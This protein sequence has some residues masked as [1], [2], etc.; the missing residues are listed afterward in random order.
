MP[1]QRTTLAAG[2]RL[3]VEQVVSHSLPARWSIPYQ[4]AS[5][6]VLFPGTGAT[7]LRSA[8]GELLADPLTAFAL[9][10]DAPYQLRPWAGP[11]ASVVVSE[12]LREQTPLLPDAAAWLLPPSALFRLRC[13]WRALRQGGESV[14][15]TS[16]LLFHLLHTALPA[17][18]RVPPVVRRARQ[19]LI[20]QT[21][22]RLSLGDLADAAC[23]TPYHLARTFRRHTGMSVH[24]YRHSLRLVAALERL[25]QGERDLAGLGYDLGYSSQ[26][27]FG[28]VF[29]RTIG[30]TPAQARSRL[31]A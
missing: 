4:A 20:E 26:S 30:V 17:R 21:G 7:E 29:R 14:E 23:T 19:V 24:Q 3:R 22:M 27:H 11:R 25:D 8:A 15:G 10:A 2:A 18:P 12:V 16:R 6:R 31:A 13:H 5:R 1:Q 9:P 28:A